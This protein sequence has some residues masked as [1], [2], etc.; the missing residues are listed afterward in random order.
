M[1]L[2]SQTE[3]LRSRFTPVPTGIHIGFCI[4]ATVVFLLIYFR[5]KEVSSLIWA[6][7]C[8]AT[9]ILQFYH[10]N[11]TAL[12]VGICEIVLFAALIFVSLREWRA[13]REAEKAKKLQENPSEGPAPEADDLED[14]DK[15]VRSEMQKLAD[16][17]NDVIKNAFEDH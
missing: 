14:I 15:L 17:G 2:P 7:I 6:L 1:F 3:M 10:D 12:A 16:D 9:L 8:D 5:K 11:L 4:F 13:R